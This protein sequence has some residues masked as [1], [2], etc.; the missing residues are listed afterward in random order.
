VSLRSRWVLVGTLAAAIVAVN[1]A[2]RELDQATR[3]PG[4][5]TSS[6]YA[7]GPDG[8]AAYAE[9]LRRF[10]RP[11]VQLRAAPAETDLDPASTLVLLDVGPIGRADARAVRE[12][13][14]GGGRLVYGGRPSSLSQLLDEGLRWSPRPAGTAVAAPEA[15]GLGRVRQVRSDG[16]GVWQADD[17]V[18]LESPA[19]ALA[20]AR[21]VGAGEAVLLADASP[22]HNRL[23]AEADNAAFGLA[24]AGPAGR[25]VVFGESFHGYGPA[26]GLDAIPSNWWLAF[27][28]LGLAA[29]VLALARGRRLGPPELPGRELPPA[30]VEFAEALA[31]QLAKA[32][33]REAGVRTA[34]RLA[35]DRLLRRLRLAPDA[36]DDTVRHAA[37]AQGLDPV[38]V[39]A[40]LGT[41]T[42][43]ADLQAVG[44]A[45][46]RLEREDAA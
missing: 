41:G 11:V 44:S 14:R 19:G 20:V 7:T 38:L 30:R 40:A 36:P 25:P 46:R 9:L 1:L 31:V 13:L 34:R 8:A 43:D 35:R 16:L 10:D 37:A 18:L 39:D 22:L 5:P 12:F 17:G 6:S 15:A 27:A 33:P 4:G 21:E 32:R 24:A 28:G 29:V 26:S 42:R 45:L 3:S 23:L 2:L